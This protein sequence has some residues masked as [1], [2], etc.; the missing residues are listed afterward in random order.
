MLSIPRTVARPRQLTASWM[1]LAAPAERRRAGGR[2]RSTGADGTLDVP[3]GADGGKLVAVR[4]S[5][6]GRE[7]ERS[8]AER[9]IESHVNVHAILRP[10]CTQTNA[11][12]PWLISTALLSW[13]RA[14]L[15]RND[16]QAGGN[17]RPKPIAD[18]GGT[19]SA[20]P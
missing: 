5:L 9:L 16:R 19:V 12:R 18:G 2:G 1:P 17:E 13:S 10:L 4:T 20:V 8:F 11:R 7:D 6:N 15:Q 14:L 3:L